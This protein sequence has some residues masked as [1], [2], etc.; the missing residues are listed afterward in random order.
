[1]LYQQ[2]LITTEMGTR[3]N[4]GNVEI[5]TP[6]KST[7]KPIKRTTGGKKLLYNFKKK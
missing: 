3:F 1:M 5:K 2:D 7:P 6:N 4:S